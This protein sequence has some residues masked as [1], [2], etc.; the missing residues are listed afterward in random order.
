M[1]G[2]VPVLHRSLLV[3]VV[4]L[5]QIIAWAFLLEWWMR[6]LIMNVITIF[7]MRLTFCTYWQVFWMFSTA[8]MPGTYIFPSQSYHLLK[9]G[10]K[11]CSSSSLL[12]ISPSSKLCSPYTDSKALQSS[13]ACLYYTQV[14][15][16]LGGEALIT[17]FLL[18]FNHGL[19][20]EASKT[21]HSWRSFIELIPMYITSNRFEY[22][23]IWKLNTQIVSTIHNFCKS[24]IFIK[25]LVES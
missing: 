10:F 18:L 11:N 5:F 23:K 1:L 20:P 13:F 25:N 22:S 3:A 15:F 19:Q 12:A 6:H 8:F 2:G 7:R 24:S 16:V 9:S 17:R 4:N 21:R 14:L